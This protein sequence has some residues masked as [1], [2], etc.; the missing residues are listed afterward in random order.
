MG[1]SRLFVF[2]H[3]RCLRFDTVRDKRT[4]ELSWVKLKRRNNKVLSRNYHQAFRRCNFP[5]TSLSRPR[6]TCLT[7]SH[8]PWLKNKPRRYWKDKAPSAR[9]CWQAKFLLLDVIPPNPKM[10][11]FLVLLLYILKKTRQRR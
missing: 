8:Q 11:R 9:E 3:C 6:C 1:A 4:E 10:S 5:P 7:I 2:G